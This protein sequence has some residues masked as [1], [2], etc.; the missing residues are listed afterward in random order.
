VGN[1]KTKIAYSKAED[2]HGYQKFT[3]SEVVVSPK[4]SIRK[5]NALVLHMF[6][7]F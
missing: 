3:L 1:K 4:V 5:Q 2:I 6:N 7:T